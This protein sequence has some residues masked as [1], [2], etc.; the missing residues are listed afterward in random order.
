MT[1]LDTTSWTV[2]AGARDGESEARSRFVSTYL[3][4]VRSYFEARWGASRGAVEDA[5]QDV[6]LDCFREDGALGR[7][8]AARGGSF[9]AFLHGIARKVAARYEESRRIESGRVDAGAEPEEL[10]ARELRLSRAFDRAWADGL[11]AAAVVRMDADAVALGEEAVRRVEILRMRFAEDLPIREIAKRWR[12]EAP[13]LH[14]E[15]ARAREEFREALLAELRQTNDGH[16]ADR[17][18]AVLLDIVREGSA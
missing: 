8:R 15:Y 7:F 10:A 17:E 9:R 4:A 11:L 12:I 6:F 2:I 13:R 1:R 18:C 5:T 14:R 16:A 3:P